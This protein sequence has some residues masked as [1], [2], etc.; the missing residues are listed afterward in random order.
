MELCTE[1]RSPLSTSL[2]VLQSASVTTESVC[3]YVLCSYCLVF[4]SIPKGCLR[5]MSFG[6][7]QVMVSR[8]IAGLMTD[9]LGIIWAVRYVIHGYGF[10]SKWAAFCKCSIYLSLLLIL[11]RDAHM[12]RL[13]FNRFNNIIIY[14]FRQLFFFLPLPLVCE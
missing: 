11:P 13:V 4:G 1:Y 2:Y 6:R 7:C 5:F 3:M 12:L 10:E 8:Y 9:R 14:L